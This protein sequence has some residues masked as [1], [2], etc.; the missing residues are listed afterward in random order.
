M[1]LADV[2]SCL[3]DNI[4]SEPE[5]GNSASGDFEGESVSKT[6]DRHPCT[7]LFK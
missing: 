5:G 2:T 3:K 6:E 1:P 7:L 4:L